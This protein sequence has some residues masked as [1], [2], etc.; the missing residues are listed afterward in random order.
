MS[1]NPDWVFYSDDRQT[2]ADIMPRLVASFP[3][4][5]PRWE[6]HL[7]LWNGE[8]AGGFNDIAEFVRFVVLRRLLPKRPWRTLVCLCDSLA[9]FPAVRLFFFLLVSWQQP[10]LET[11]RNYDIILTFLLFCNILIPLV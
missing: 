2:E 3:G 4:F 10:T 11:K 6:R 5:R 7:Q 8:P 9:H 1:D